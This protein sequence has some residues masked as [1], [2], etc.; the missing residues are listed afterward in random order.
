MKK[1]TLGSLIVVG[2]GIKS[3][4]HLSI[5]AQTYIQKSDKVL[6]SANEPIMEAWIKKNSINSESLN[7]FENLDPLRANCYSAMAAHILAEVKKEQNICVVLY[8][9]PTFFAMPALE[10]AWGLRSEGYAVK[11]LPAISAED[12]L[13]ADLLIDPG[14][15]GCQSYEAT[16]FLIREKKAD[17]S[18]HL[19]LWQVGLIGAF[20]SIQNHNNHIG[21]NL[22]YKYLKGFYPDNH[23]IV[24]YEA[25]LYSHL[26]P[27][28]EISTLERLSFLHLTAITTLYIPPTHLSKINHQ[29][30]NQLNF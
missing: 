5:E 10:A 21:I 20:G 30:L 8:G 26:E 4:S 28:I 9:H 29:I 22:L 13:F 3:I 15:T 7:R 25:S 12:C 1:K 6:Y 24:S 23:K 27:K 14:S 19:I 2:S 18:N 16:D 17:T 11:I